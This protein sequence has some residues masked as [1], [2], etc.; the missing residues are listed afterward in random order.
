MK[1][2]SFNITQQFACLNEELLIVIY[3][4]IFKKN[5]TL[6]K[7]KYSFQILH[8]DCLNNVFSHFY[9]TNNHL[10][11]S[12]QHYKISKEIPA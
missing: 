12:H 9:P 1:L 4:S 10:T 3:G 7:Q 8:K 11:A 6:Q 2:I 5:C